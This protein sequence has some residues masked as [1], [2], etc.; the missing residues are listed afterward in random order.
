MRRVSRV[1]DAA[2][3]AAEDL[4]LG[5]RMT[6][7]VDEGLLARAAD[8]LGAAPVEAAVRRALD[9]GLAAWREE[10]RGRRLAPTERGWLQGNE[11]F[12]IMWDL[13]SGD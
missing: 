7:G 8:V 11:L 6:R 12:S 13:A 4:M 10:G 5:M 3:A 1:V 2:E 9:R